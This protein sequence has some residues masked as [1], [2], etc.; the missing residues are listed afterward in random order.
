MNASPDIILHAEG[1]DVRFGGVKALDNVNFALRTGELRCVIGPNGAGKTT[2]FKCLTGQLTPSRGTI[3]FKG[4]TLEGE[5]SY[6][7]ARSG[8][9]I[10]TQVPSLFDQLTAREHLWIALR[11]IESKTDREAEIDKVFVRFGITDLASL[12]VGAMAHGQRQLVELAMVISANPDLILLD[13]PAAGMTHE[14]SARLIAIVREINLDH[15]IVIVEHD[16]GFIREVAQAVTVFNHGAILT[17]G[18][19]DD[20][21]SDPKVRAV[22]LGDSQNG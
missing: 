9:G 18:S 19:A 3:R 4:K 12:Q 21:L 17:E 2:F 16:M 5:D 8:I 15:T 1:V 22:Y 13:E 10:K 6:R 14:E 11:T 7:I 20:V